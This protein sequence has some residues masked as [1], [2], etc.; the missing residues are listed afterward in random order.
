MK[1]TGI[2]NLRRFAG[3]QKSLRLPYLQTFLVFVAFA[4]MVAS[5]YWYVSGIENNHLMRNVEN[6]FAST[7]MKIE[8][9]LQ[10]PKSLLAG[11]SQTVR[12]KILNKDTDKLQEYFIEITD[13]FSEE[14]VMLGFD[15]LYGYFYESGDIDGRKRGLPK[16]YLATERPWYIAAVEAN[17]KITATKP[18]ISVGSGETV[19]TY[20]RL[21]F[22]NNGKPLGVVGLD[23]NLD[24]ISKYAVD[25]RIYEGSYGMLMDE[26]LNIIAHP[27][28]SYF[29][30]T[31]RDMKDGISIEN[32]L[33]LKKE[34]SGRKAI[35]YL[36]RQSVLF[37]RQFPNG[38]YMAVLT[39]ES[40]YNENLIKMIKILSAL[41]LVLAIVLSL[42]LQHVLSAKVKTDE[43]I[44]SLLNSAPL[45]ITIWDPKSFALINCNME[46][47]RLV[48]L[49]SKRVYIEKFTE[50]S[51]EYQPDG[52]KTS[53]KLIEIFDKTMKDGIYRYNWNQHTVDGEVIPFQVNTVR[54]K[55]MGGYI[56]VSYAQ[57]MREI[58]AAFAKIRK[59]DEFTQV[60]FKSM[61]LACQLWNM[62][63]QCIMCN[64]EAMRVYRVRDREYFLN[65]FFDFSPE[66]Q[67][68]SRPSKEK[69]REYLRKGFE[70]GYFRFKWI[71]KR[72]DGEEFPAE[73]TMICA[74]FSGEPALLTYTRDLSEEEAITKERQKT[75]IAEAS[76]KAKSKFLAT[77]SHEIRTPMNAILGITEIQLQDESL[78]PH[79]REAFSEI[80]NSGD[81]LI[82]IIN[83]ILDL[84][85]IETG[86][87]ELNIAKY[88]VASLINDTVHLNMTRSS[89]PVE[90][91][92]NVD[93]NMPAELLGD[94]LRIKQI[95]NN[96]LSNAYKYTEEGGVKL[97]VYTETENAEE[98]D[99]VLVFRVC[100]TG[101]GM[102]T[103]QMDRLFKEYSRFNM[104]ANRTIEG[105]GL[106]LNI[107]WS[108]IKMMNGTISVDSEPDKGSTFTV[109]LPQ[110]KIGSKV[111]G[112]ELVE[113]LQN[114]HLSSS[115]QMKRTKIVREYMPYGKVL[116]VDDVDSNL[117]VAKGL[118]AP[119]GLAIDIASS[120][121]EAIEKIKSG[122]VYDIVFMDHM[123]PKMD[124][125]EATKI[126]RDLGY[127]QPIVALTANAVIGQSK[128]FLES[129]FDEFMPKPV[130]IRLLNAVLN[131]F[132]RN[133]QPPEIIEEARKY[134]Q[135]MDESTFRSSVSKYTALHSVFL[136]DV[137]RAL[138]IIKKT[139]EN[140]NDITDEDLHLFAIS[141]H[142]MKSAL[143]NIGESAASRL[144]FTLEKASKERNIDILKKQTQALIE[145]IRMIMDRIEQENKGLNS[146]SDVDENPDFL[147]EQLQIICEA[148]EAYDER[149]V[150]AALDALKK[151]SWKKET[152]ILIDEIAEQLL[153]G[154][155]DKAGKLAAR[156]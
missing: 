18:Y 134:R 53:E 130:D 138:P 152:R 40:E 94:E 60:M 25:T 34:I 66:R 136:L 61:P 119:Y 65:N 2:K 50:M 113:S 59:T 74:M 85:R 105:T 156:Q 77:M 127:D 98:D 1:I 46:A 150:N 96:L 4:L 67:P 110:K 129:G 151:L 149:P 57:D 153:Y 73:I 101:I 121:F 99:T 78:A 48:G 155:F 45:A 79:I 19:V 13:L 38:W 17:G 27:N 32:E 56:V 139:L 30:K 93:E 128:L 82:G 41:G 22:D 140:I 120:G 107:T 118:M 80:Y 106:G 70:E 15:G 21:I 122:M 133:K 90:F 86:K 103:N 9:D 71:H 24:R 39:P 11:F 55:Y 35:D 131:K 63:L 135:S 75:E 141:V 146:D 145:D 10:E 114:F 97:F 95:L 47:V 144:A 102:S 33:R 29:G 7:Q 54:L 3:I 62:E 51:P 104:E 132:V 37:I 64:D 69:G 116:I 49:T 124:G 58:N 87:M 117:Y 28:R 23:V 112:K 44:Q 100:D 126:I 42:V 154:D 68:C 89:K 72:G 20:A 108:L 14:G 84:S 5:S 83:D 6:T 148:C 16:G 91:E 111:L 147:R 81:L 76:N 43:F 12:Y 143:A 123:M 88:E 115:F 142:A 31:L 26:Q 92:L 36:G 109:R 137:K 8:A 125:I 52:Q